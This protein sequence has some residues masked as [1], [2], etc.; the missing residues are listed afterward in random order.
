M[1]SADIIIPTTISFN[2][3]RSYSLCG[4]RIKGFFLMGWKDMGAMVI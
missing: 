4:L 3:N 1:F 2:E